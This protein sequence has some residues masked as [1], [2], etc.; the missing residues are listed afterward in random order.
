M[1]LIEQGKGNT[2]QILMG[3]EKNNLNGKGKTQSLLKR[4]TKR[5]M[6]K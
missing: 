5:H 2:K 3:K 4:K 6:H 1:L